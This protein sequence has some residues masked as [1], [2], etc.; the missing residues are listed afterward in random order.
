[1]LDLILGYLLVIV[2]LFS[3]NIGLFLGN[4]KFNDKKNTFISALMG[5]ILLIVMAISSIL[6]IN[7]L[8]Y[9]SYVFILVSIIIFTVLYIYLKRNNLRFS[10]SI[11]IFIYYMLALILSSQLAEH[12]IFNYSL[13]I[14]S[15]IVMIVAVQLSKLLMYAKRSY[16]VIIGEYMSLMGILI[17]ILGLTNVS[18]MQL[19]HEMFSSFLI[20]TPTYQLIYVI[21]GIIFVLIIGFYLNDKN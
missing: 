9:L 14:V 11:I 5:I 4:F 18:I 15:I 12:S 1:M 16:N 6:T 7:L 19:N 21:I 10:L 3:V 17:F 20:L 2:I 13:V 8:D